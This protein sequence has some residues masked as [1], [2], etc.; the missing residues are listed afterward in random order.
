ML[1]A[2]GPRSTVIGT[3]R[4][5][6]DRLP[7][8]PATALRRLGRRLL[9]RTPSTHLIV[10]GLDLLAEPAGGVGAAT[11]PMCGTVADVFLPYGVKAPRPD[12]RCPGCNSLER[13]RLVW[14][15]FGLHTDLFDDLRTGTGTDRGT[16]G[17]VR[18]LLHIA[19]EPPME[20]RLTQLPHLRYLSADLEPGKA[21]VEMDI[22]AIDRPDDTFDVIY[23]SHVLEHIP[24]DVQA[25]RELRRV[26]KPDGWAVLEVPMHGPT[27]REDPTVTDPEER[28]R[29]FGQ[30]D[31]VRMY[32]HDGEYE[33]RLRA[34]G[35]DVTVVALTDELGPAAARRFRLRPGED[36]YLCRKGP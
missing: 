30:H 16:T 3:A 21:M 28:T 8:A 11:C 20:D 19:P 29:R 4:T 32:G 35:F 1:A 34:A 22:T 13:H 17:P 33:R 18:S 31:H 23:A 10:P 9:G 15:F 6:I 5:V 36:V 14:L 24:D 12:C 27:T 2:S 25:M 7:R 26:L